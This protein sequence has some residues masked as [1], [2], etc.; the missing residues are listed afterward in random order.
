[1]M[2]TKYIIYVLGLLVAQQATAQS[3]G[4]EYVTPSQVELR[5]TG[6]NLQVKMDLT[7]GGKA[8]KKMERVTVTPMLLGSAGESQPLE[9]FV[10]SGKSRRKLEIRKARL[11]RQ[12]T[13]PEQKAYIY[14]KE[15]P[16]QPWME[17]AR[18]MI[19]ISKT[20]CANCPAGS[21]LVH[22]P[23]IVKLAPRKPYVMRPLPNFVTPDAEPI[24]NRAETGSARIEFLSGKSVI[25]PDYKGNAAELIKINQAIRQ[26]LADTLAK[27]SSI[28]LTAYSSPEGA[29]VTNEK[30]SRARAEALKEYVQS[31]NDLKGVSVQTQAVAEDWKTLREMME[32]S[33]YTWKEAALKI[34]D[35]TDVPDNRE[36]GLKTLAGGKPYQM[37]LQEWFPK[38]RRTDYRLD[39]SVKDFTVNQGR[40]II[41]T[42]PAQMS[43]NEMFHVANSYE[44]GS[45]EFNEVF[46]I[47]VRLF[48]ENPVANINAAAAAISRGD[49]TMAEKYLGK[50]E[51]DARA[52]NNQAVYHMLSGNISKAKEC[53]ARLKE[54]TQ[55]T[56]HNL[57]EIKL[58]EENNALLEK[59]GKR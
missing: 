11:K 52:A 43:L 18:L 44:K 54:E 34:I 40:E 38:L 28:V 49:A 21:T 35:G 39:Y 25:I 31:N 15:F 47:A 8:V 33:E 36:K 2:K 51:G 5:E 14:N 32:R 12:A 37:I 27:V 16:F 42:R 57:N 3:T 41:R 58:K 9:P 45:P 59:Y 6:D 30:L 55:E 23:A 7:P 1:M 56:K 13:L 20:G 46:D 17:E 29:Y 53:L 10:L 26:V 19:D 22:I 48:P 4:K 50:V 24:K